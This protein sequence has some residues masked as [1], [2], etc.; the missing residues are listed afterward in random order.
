MKKNLL[1]IVGAVAL[2]ALALIIASS[3]GSSERKLNERVTL[4]AKD[5]IPYG[6]YTAYH[7]LPKLFP[8][9]YLT[10][11]KNEPLQWSNIYP[12][13]NNQAVVLVC[14]YFYPEKNELKQ[15]AEFA[16][17]GNHVFIIAARISYEV[18]SFFGFSSSY[19]A[20]EE[21]F[22]NENTDS[23][24]LQLEVPPFSNKET[25]IYPGRRMSYT[26]TLRDSAH[27]T[28][29]GRNSIGQPNFFY[30]K[31]GEGSISLHLSPFAFTNYF[32]LHKNNI[33]YYE[34]ALSVIPSSVS[35][36]TW[37]EYYLFHQAKNE[38]PNF[39]KVLMRYPSFKWALLTACGSI[40]L[41]ALLYM[42]RRQRQIPVMRKPVNESLDFIKT[43]GRLYHDKRDHTDLARK[44][45]VYFLDQVR[46]RF[47]LSTHAMDEEFLNSLH[48]KSGY[49][50]E[51]LNEIINFIKY[52]QSNPSISESQLIAFHKQLENF[53]L[54][55]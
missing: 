37:N 18:N 34:Q 11:D 5:K 38:E 39:L 13:N 54:K 33:H 7:F 22:K 40:F 24:S 31:A 25:F 41:F 1:Y 14:S 35:R 53:Y 23:L 43:I 17:K 3:S 52:L 10:I 19:Y 15:L 55:S 8:Q 28:I 6:Y 50:K 46:Q 30:F 4:R 26:A 29:L 36:L 48:A 21:G 51:G 32:I 9:A 45:S 47:L 12:D 42:R 2:I 49:D 20:E 27:G 44:M 16:R